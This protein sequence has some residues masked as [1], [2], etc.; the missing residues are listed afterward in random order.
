MELF[1]RLQRLEDTFASVGL[2]PQSR[3]NRHY[4]RS[5]ERREIFVSKL[6]ERIIHSALGHA[7]LN[8]HLGKSNADG[9]CVQDRD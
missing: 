6:R 5:G 4:L 1:E 7:Q 2:V 8:A 3:R 9:F